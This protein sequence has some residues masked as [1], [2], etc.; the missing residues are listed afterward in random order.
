[1]TY[2]PERSALRGLGASGVVADHVFQ[3]LALSF[4]GAAGILGVLGN[5]G[6]MGVALFLALSIYLLMGSLDGNRDL[7]HYFRRRILRIWPLYFAMCGVLFL[8]FD[9]SLSDLAWNVTF[10]AVWAPAHQFHNTLS[11]GWPMTYVVWTLQVEEWAYLS[12]PLLALLSHR[13]RLVV[14]VGLVSTMGAWLLTTPDYFTVW[15]WLACYGWGL[16]AYEMRPAF[17]APSD[18]AYTLCRV[19]AY[20]PLTLALVPLGFLFGWPL[21][22]LFVGPALVWLVASPPRALADR[23]LV[24]VG[25]CSYALYLVHLLLL[26]YL[27]LVGLVLA[28]PLAWLIESA[29]RGK[30]MRR[31]V[32]GVT[33]LP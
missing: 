11:T 25:E 7:R 4:A 3:L 27:G 8:L 19:S 9:R 14:G 26:E 24:G 32:A 2:S 21:G 10:L 15:P 28:Y 30:E 16:L 23:V 17:S 5:V 6:W 31:R 12:F 1:V 20:G 29:Q 13:W 22:L 33:L 18:G